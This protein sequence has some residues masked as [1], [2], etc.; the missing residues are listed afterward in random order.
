MISWIEEYLFVQTKLPQKLL[1]FLLLPFSAIYC[2]VVISK[3]FLAKPKEYGIDIISVGNLIVGGS[4]KTPFTI[5]LAKHIDKKVAIVLRGY[6]RE[7]K[8]LFIVADNNE[9]LCD[10]KESG[11]E[12]ML[13]STSLTSCTVIVCEDRVKAILKAKSLGCE[14]VLLDDGFSKVNIKKFDILI[15]PK[16]QFP[17]CCIPSGAYREPKSFYK[18]ADLV[19]NEDVDFTK[20]VTIVDETKRMILITAISKPQRLDE[21][22]PENIVEKLYFKDHS[23]FDENELKNLMSKYEATSI[24]TTEKDFV[25][26]KGFDVDISLMK[27]EYILDNQKIIKSCEKFFARN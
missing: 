21:F 8:G 1:S 12:A 16:R 2:L 22:L 20:K 19:V 17:S 26:M 5:A 14:V 23:F 4:G 24:L 18:Y 3:R 9:I 15:K 10:V 25:K 7:S 11:D 6:G 27:L 13:Y